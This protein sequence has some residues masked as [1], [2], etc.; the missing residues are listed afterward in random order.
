MFICHPSHFTPA[1]RIAP[2]ESVLEILYV[3]F[4]STTECFT[5]I[6]P[7]RES[8]CSLL[9]CVFGDEKSNC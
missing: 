1:I 6:G 5:S 8:L 7:N 2:V 4:V 3:E 9:T